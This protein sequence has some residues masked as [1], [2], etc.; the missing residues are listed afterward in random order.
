M[1]VILTQDQYVGG[2]MRKRGTEIDLESNTAKTLIREGK[3]KKPG[4]LKKR[5]LKK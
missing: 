3:V 5:K 4:F 1:I 2:R